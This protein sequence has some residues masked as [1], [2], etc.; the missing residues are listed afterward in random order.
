MYNKEKL[1]ANVEA[2]KGYCEKYSEWPK[3]YAQAR[4]EKEQ[5]SNILYRK[6]VSMNFGNK[7]KDFKYPKVRNCDGVLIK[8]VLDKLYL[9][10]GMAN[11][12]NERFPEYILMLTKEFIDKNG[13]FPDNKTYIYYWLKSKNY[14]S[15]TENFDYYDY[16]LEDGSN[17]EKELRKLEALN[18][19]K[20]TINYKNVLYIINEFCKKYDEWPRYVANDTSLKSKIGGQIY[21]WLKST[22]YFSDNFHVDGLSE[23][24]E[25]ALKL[26]IDA[27]YNRY[28]LKN[29]LRYEKILTKVD[30]IEKYCKTYGEWPQASRGRNDEKDIKSRSLYIWLNDHYYKCSNKTFVYKNIVDK[31]GKPIKNILDNLYY[32]Y[33]KNNRQSELYPIGMYE[34]ILNF[35]NKYHVFPFNVVK[36]ILPIERESNKLY[37]W[38]I[39]N[40]YFVSKDQFS[41]SSYTLDEGTNLFDALKELELSF[42]SVSK[43]LLYEYLRSYCEKYDEWPVY[44]RFN[45]DSNRLS[46]LRLMRMLLTTKYDR[47]SNQFI[48]LNE[49]DKYG[50]NYKEKLDELYEKYYKNVKKYDARINKFID[51]IILFTKTYGYWP[52]GSNDLSSDE[53]KEN[54]RLSTWLCKSCYN[55]STKEFLYDDYMY[56]DDMSVKRV[57]DYLSAVYT[58]R[59][60]IKDEEFSTLNINISKN[61]HNAGLVIYYCVLKY[62]RARVMSDII[63]EKR[64]KE[65]IEKLSNYYFNS[66]ELLSILNE[67]VAVQRD[68]FFKKYIEAS[69]GNDTNVLLLYKNLYILTDGM[70][71]KK[72]SV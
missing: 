18:F 9:K 17:L 37:Q 28:H 12:H 53:G 35:T 39:R 23:D 7:N 11:I 46:A 40:N 59:A 16:T 25:K 38:L 57:L 64:Y 8:E 10:Y 58:R 32:K 13:F 20:S 29:T 24:K 65:K 63:E 50:K 31:N 41:Y 71:T 51:R 55:S 61:S 19:R 60:R 27:L 68:Y 66:D 47:N 14:F 42:S 52:G 44:G 56:N 43:E 5:L 3:F 33:G 67:D 2:V 22:D 6:L 49:Y 48:Y 36:P 62:L 72:T 21:R 30:E 69:I 70:K 34:Q 54:N 26:E 4:N 45:D 1:L 15:K